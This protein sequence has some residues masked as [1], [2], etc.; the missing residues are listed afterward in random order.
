MSIYAVDYNICK[1][2]LC[3]SFSL[4]VHQWFYMFCLSL[5][6]SQRVFCRWLKMKGM[7]EKESIMGVRGRQNNPSLGNTVWHHSASL[8]MPDSN[9]RDGFFCLPLTPMIDSYILAYRIRISA[10]S[11]GASK[12]Y[13]TH[14]YPF[15]GK[16]KNQEFSRDDIH[17][18]YRSLQHAIVKVDVTER[19]DVTK[20]HDIFIT[21]SR[22]SATEVTA[23]STRVVRRQRSA[24]KGWS[25]MNT[26]FKY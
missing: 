16:D 11:T 24:E 1:H 15:R 17:W 22:T 21:T 7:Q 26:I 10:N 4:F 3:C 8:V 9:P 6:A 12:S 2:D 13:L 18:L 23:L 5:Y 14:P 20:R 19:Y 25:D